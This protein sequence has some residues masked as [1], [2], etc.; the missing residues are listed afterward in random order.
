MSSSIYNIAN[1]SSNT[2]YGKNDIVINSGLYYY[3]A[4]SHTSSASFATD[5]AA[6]D[7]NGNLYDR[8]QNKPYFFW[9]PSYKGSNKNEP[10]V[11]KIQFGDSYAQYSPDGINN[12]LLNYNFTFEVR[13]LN[14][15]TAI[16]HF[17]TVR[18]GSESFIFS[19]PAPRGQ[20]LRFICPTFTDIQEFFQ[21]YTIQA[22]FQQNPV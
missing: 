2:Q 18:N 9:K 14:E 4:I 5:L 10:R 22:T 6:G 17:L 19:P 21:N 7:W 13:E 20:L 16:L 8:G 11:R 15:A 1:W 12:L 3:T